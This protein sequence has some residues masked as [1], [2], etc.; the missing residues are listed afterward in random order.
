VPCVFDHQGIEHEYYRTSALRAAS[1][2]RR[3]YYT[4]EQ[5]KVLEQ[6]RLVWRQGKGHVFLSEHDLR[7][8]MKVGYVDDKLRCIVSQGIDF[9][10]ENAQESFASDKSYASD[11]LFCGNLTQPRNVDPLREFIQLARAKIEQGSFPRE[12]KMRLFGKGAPP[13]LVALCDGMN[14]EY[15]GF[16][17]DLTP[18]LASTRVVFCY[19]PT[20]SGVKTKIVEAFGFG[21]A[22]LCD[23]L[24]AAAL[25][26]LF[27]MSSNPISNTMEE[28]VNHAQ[29]F[30]RGEIVTQNIE[31]FVRANYSWT[32]LMRKFCDFMHLVIEESRA[33]AP[34]KS[35]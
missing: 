19:L 29:L 21:K 4:W 10:D 23:P 15:H 14:F 24:S 18:Y 11:V 32:A 5:N 20:G 7:C 9:P 12:F 35:L 26:N 22:V 30:L 28:A 33:G 6:E 1:P 3:A 8:A 25:P 27:T 16:V 34:S 31:A 13:A 17:P 2:F